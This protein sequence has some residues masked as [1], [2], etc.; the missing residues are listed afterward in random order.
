MKKLILILLIIPMLSLAAP[1]FT[2]GDCSFCELTWADGQKYVGSWKN[3]LQHGAGTTTWANGEKYVG[4]YENGDANG[5]GTYT[6]P[7]GRKYVGSYKNGKRYGTGT[8][9]NPNGEKYVGSWKNDYRNGTGTSTWPNGE[10]YVGFWKDGKLDKNSIQ[11]AQDEA[12]AQGDCITW[13]DGS[14]TRNGFPV[15]SCEGNNIKSESVNSAPAI[16]KPKVSIN[17]EKFKKECEELGFTPNTESFG[18]C[19]LELM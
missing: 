4:S 7:N 18:E 17:I 13:E 14:S 6:W 16:I 2:G 10:K 1:K 3:R 19:V 15:A 9:T 12:K 11:R 8:L 5:T